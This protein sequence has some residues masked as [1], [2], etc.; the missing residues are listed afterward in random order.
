MKK[1]KLAKVLRMAR[2]SVRLHF[3]SYEIN[4]DD[5]TNSS[6]VDERIARLSQVKHDLEAAITA[7]SSLQAEAT[8]RKGEADQLKAVISKLRE[9]KNTAESLLSVPEESFVRLVKRA[10][11]KGRMRGLI[12]GGAIGFVTGMLSSL[13][14]WYITK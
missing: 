1:G 4:F 9:D 3:I 13:L 6:T 8:D 7:V 12:E 2:I 5:L 10:V 11:S 14:A